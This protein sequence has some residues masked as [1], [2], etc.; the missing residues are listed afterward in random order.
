MLRSR[1]ITVI[2]FTRFSGDSGCI[3]FSS[4]SP[5]SCVVLPCIVVEEGSIF[6][7]PANR[8]NFEDTPRCLN[9]LSNWLES[10]QSREVTTNWL[11]TNIFQSTKPAST[12]F[13]RPRFKLPAL[14]VTPLSRFFFTALKVRAL[15][16][17]INTGPAGI[18]NQI[19]FYIRCFFFFTYFQPIPICCTVQYFR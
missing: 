11:P 14:P 16:A 13:T 2:K 3:I 15:R 9:K 19:T 4:G 1:A 17:M 5:S 6:E 18:T 10:Q 8:I 7:D 12:P